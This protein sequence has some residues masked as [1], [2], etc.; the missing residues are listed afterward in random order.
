MRVEGPAAF[1]FLVALLAGFGTNARQ[2]AEAA[3]EAVKQN[4]TEKNFNKGKQPCNVHILFISSTIIIEHISY[5]V[6]TSVSTNV[7]MHCLKFHF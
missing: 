5:T 7:E 6:F 2:P 4:E 1:G 3:E